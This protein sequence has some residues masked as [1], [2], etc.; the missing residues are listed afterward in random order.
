MVKNSSE[1]N[2]LQG[3]HN[4]LVNNGFI[5][6]SKEKE[7]IPY[8]LPAKL[9]KH[10]NLEDLQAATLQWKATNGGQADKVILRLYD[11]PMESVGLDPN[12]HRREGTY[13]KSFANGKY[14]YKEYLFRLKVDQN[15]TKLEVESFVNRLANQC[16]LHECQ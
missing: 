7:S 6:K 14:P 12:F 10:F 15:K 13:Q 1:Y 4:C 5:A 2:L 8:F 16:C 11:G 9:Y 3:F